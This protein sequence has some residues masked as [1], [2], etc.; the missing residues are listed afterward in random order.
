MNRIQ[1]RIHYYKP[2]NTLFTGD[3][4]TAAA[5]PYNLDLALFFVQ[6]MESRSHRKLL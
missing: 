1:K 6:R 4:I 3:V 5:R 2:D